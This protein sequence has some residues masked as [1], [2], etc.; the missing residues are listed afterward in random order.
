MRALLAVLAIL[1]VVATT[2][3]VAGDDDPFLSPLSVEK[4]DYP[5]EAVEVKEREREWTWDVMLNGSFEITDPLG[6]WW[7]W[8]PDVQ[9]YWEPD[10]SREGRHSMIQGRITGAETEY[11]MQCWEANE[12]SE[13][14][15]FILMLSYAV[16]S[17]DVHHLNWSRLYFILQEGFNW[18]RATPDFN[19]LDHYDAGMFFHWEDVAFYMEGFEDI[20][21]YPTCLVVESFLPSE[22]RSYFWRDWFMFSVKKGDTRILLPFIR[23]D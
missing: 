3:G 6:A 17:N 13:Y 9:V 16:E 19:V 20:T 12:L 14:H 15:D 22:Y 10:K 1:A 2:L 11:A 23:R 4:G 7:G 18:Y 5:V 21:Q 8:Y